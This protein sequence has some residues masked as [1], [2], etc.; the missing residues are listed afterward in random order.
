MVRRN[1][2]KRKIQERAVVNVSRG[3]K[4][5]ED[6]RVPDYWVRASKAMRKIMLE[7]DVPIVSSAGNDAV[8]RSPQIDKYPSVWSTD[9][10]PLTNVGSVNFN[11]FSAVDS[12]SGPLRAVSAPGVGVTCS[13]PTGTGS[14]LGTGTSYGECVQLESCLP[15]SSDA[16]RYADIFTTS[17]STSSGLIGVLFGPTE[18]TVRHI[19]WERGSQ[20]LE[21]RQ[22]H[23]LVATPESSQR[24]QCGV[25]PDR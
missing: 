10:W 20:R 7:L 9:D 3:R 14:R 22:E 11:G 2:K 17:C 5:A 23:C 4:P 24:C 15:H 16:I 12:Q 18:G 21:F 13:T 1:I 6:G 8:L 25:E 19:E